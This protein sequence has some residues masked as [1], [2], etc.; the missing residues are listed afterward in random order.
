MIEDL[1][2]EENMEISEDANLKEGNTNE[3]SS[4]EYQN[5]DV[6]MNTIFGGDSSESEDDRT[7]TLVL[8]CS[9]DQTG[10]IVGN[11]DTRNIVARVDNIV[12]AGDKAEEERVTNKIKVVKPASRNREAHICMC[13]YHF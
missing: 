10:L 6:V 3:G 7:E 8:T 9:K 11:V 1:T 2:D 13:L 12:E 4:G 5:T